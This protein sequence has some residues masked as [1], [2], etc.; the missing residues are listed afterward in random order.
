VDSE[1]TQCFSDEAYRAQ[2]SQP[3]PKIP[4]GRKPERLI[5]STGAKD[6]TSPENGGRDGNEVL[7]QKPLDKLIW[8]DGTFR[9]W[10]SPG[11]EFLSDR[12]HVRRVVD[13]ERAWVA[14]HLTAKSFEPARKPKV[15]LMKKASPI[16]GGFTQTEI[17][18]RNPVSTSPGS[19]QPDGENSSKTMHDIE[20]VIGGAIIDNHQL[21][22]VVL[23]IPH[24]LE[25]G[26]DELLTVVRGHDN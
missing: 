17:A 19:N 24:T 12:V 9:K 7:N 22:P 18:H 25:C 6:R 3:Q 16:A 11:S 20:R 13:D 26:G 10:T 14:L 4:V 8:R 2:S 1:G 5:Q 23:L 15:I 21:N